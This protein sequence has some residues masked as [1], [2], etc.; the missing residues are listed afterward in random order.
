MF[1][2][3]DKHSFWLPVYFSNRLHS[4]K[5]GLC[6]AGS[7]TFYF[8]TKIRFHF[9]HSDTWGG[10]GSWQFYFSDR[11]IKNKEN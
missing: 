3:N 4:G 1:Q 9:I 6:I 11:Y 7:P 5:V 10:G 2:C 8:P